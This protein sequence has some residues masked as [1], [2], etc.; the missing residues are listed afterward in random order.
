MADTAIRDLVGNVWEWCKESGGGESRICGGSCLSP[1]VYEGV[2][3]ASPDY[4]RPMKG[5]ESACDLGFRI[6][7][8]CPQNRPVPK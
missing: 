3:Y 8:S 7:V 1:V 5:N 6:A 4:A 2:D